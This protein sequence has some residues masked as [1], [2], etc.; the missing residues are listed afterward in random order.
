MFSSKFVSIFALFQSIVKDEYG[1]KK[2][3]W[4]LK[5]N[6]AVFLLLYANRTRIKVCVVNVCRPSD[7]LDSRLATP[8]GQ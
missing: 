8:Y 5:L 1:N 6:V 2:E 7:D 3:Q 4:G